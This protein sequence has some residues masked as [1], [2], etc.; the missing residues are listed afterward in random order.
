MASFITLFSNILQNPQE[1]RARSD[2]TLMKSVE[3]F[4]NILSQSE[5][6]SSEN[7][8]RMNLFV[9]E[10]V[11]IAG[12]VLE[13]ADKESHGRRRKRTEDKMEVAMQKRGLR[14]GQTPVV[15]V[16][17]TPVGET[18]PGGTL[19]PTNPNDVSHPSPYSPNSSLTPLDSLQ[20]AHFPTLHPPLQLR[21]ARRVLTHAL[22]NRRFTL[23]TQHPLPSRIPICQ[24]AGC[25]DTQSSHNVEFPT[26][27]HAPGFV[28]DAHELR[29]GLGYGVAFEW[30]AGRWSGGAELDLVEGFDGETVRIMDEGTVDNSALI[31]FDG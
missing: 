8:F 21:L 25:Y 19:R 31:G 1:P 27:C 2:F 23:N 18:S 15:E 7:T 12:L 30:R 11:K 13:R 6:E 28:A 26:T 9:Q 24:P 14:T 10:F 5:T 4:V 16:N 20:P 17:G 22:D 3:E 29:V